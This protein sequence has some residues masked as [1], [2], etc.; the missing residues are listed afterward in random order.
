MSKKKRERKSPEE[1]RAEILSAARELFS[2]KG[3]QAT[4]MEDIVAE[5]SLSKG[6]VYRYYGSKREMLHELMLQG[7]VERLKQFRPRTASGAEDREAMVELL[8]AKICDENEM[9][10]L[11]A[12]FL[13]AAATDPELS[14]L[15]EQL[16]S[17]SV[18]EI[19]AT[20]GFKER[21]ES[22]PWHELGALIDALIF[23]NERLGTREVFTQNPGFL[24]LILRRLL[25]EYL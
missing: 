11:Y 25:E 8:Y 24:K 20:I 3:Y 15:K 18:P 21:P 4:T 2:K 9:K 1:R 22:L 6:G 7:N 12:E 10:P 23:S 19:Q 13:L 14:K 5:T 16:F 17:E